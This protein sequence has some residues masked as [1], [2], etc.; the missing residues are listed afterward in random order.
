MT[1]QVVTAAQRFTSIELS[2]ELVDGR[3]LPL[4]TSHSCPACG[5][6]VGFRRSDLE[7]AD[8]S[9]RLR[10]PDAERIDTLAVE[11]EL[12]SHVFLDWYCPGCGAPRRVYCE[13]WVGG[14]HGDHGVRL[15]AVFEAEPVP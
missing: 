4:T 7:A 1:I 12:A 3:A 9:T 2:T 13:R 6:D 5:Q 8:R 14:R 11:H 10:L 15:L